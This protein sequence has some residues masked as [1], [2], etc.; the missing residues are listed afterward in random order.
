[1]TLQTITIKDYLDKK[2]LTY[3]E[4]GNELITH[5]FFN[6]CDDLSKANEAHLYFNKESGQ[7]ECKKC[8]ERGNLITLSK[9]FG[10]N[11]SDISTS[12]PIKKINKRL[13][14]EQVERCH[15][16]LPEHI[17][18]YLNGRGISDDVIDKYKLGWGNF[19]GKEWITIPITDS[20]G[21]YQFF[22]LRQDPND[23]KEKM[24]Y[25]SGT[26]AQIYGW[27]A[28]KS[29]VDKIIICEGELDRLALISQGIPAITSTHGAMTFKDDWVKMLANVNKIYICYDKDEA[30]KKGSERVEN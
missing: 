24:T 3:R 30:G 8:G 19:Y 7:Y 25:P 9:H 21:S 15:R 4:L 13:E 22:K 18:A 14:I 20:N 23:G 27:E 16:A 2:G 12:G 5:C 17:R 11:L 28:L 26:E 29:P 6:G 10:D 1:M